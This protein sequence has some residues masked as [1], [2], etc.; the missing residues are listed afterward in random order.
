M[1]GDWIAK[2]K[3]PQ[4]PN[5]AGARHIK[6]IPREHMPEPKA[7]KRTAAKK[8]GTSNAAPQLDE[9]VVVKPSNSSEDELELTTLQVDVYEYDGFTS[10]VYKGQGRD[11]HNSDGVKGVTDLT[12]TAT[13]NLWVRFDGDNPLSKDEGDKF[14]I[15]KSKF[16]LGISSW[17]DEESGEEYSCTWMIPLS[18]PYGNLEPTEW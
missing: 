15:Y 3:V 9:Q 4:P 1:W 8:S 6:G 5:M 17:I 18:M 7:K 16:K 13:R 12:R 10:T 14:T 11:S 2:S